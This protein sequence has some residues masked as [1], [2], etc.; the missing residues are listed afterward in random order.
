MAAQSPFSFPAR[1][2]R[3][4]AWARPLCES[5]P[6]AT[7]LF[8]EAADILGYDLLDVCAD[9]PAERLNS[10]VV[11]QPAIFVASLAALEALQASDPAAVDA[12][13]GDGRPEPGRIHG[14][15]LRRRAELSPTACAWCRRAARRCRPP[16]TPRPA[17]WSASSALERPQVEEL[18]RRRPRERD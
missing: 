7:Q 14:P 6:A 16:P 9:G 12:C 2:P 3:P 17:A 11:S 5:L 1:A 10:T 8:D 15:G 4:S 13:V 18:V